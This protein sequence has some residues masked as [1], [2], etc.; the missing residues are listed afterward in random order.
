MRRISTGRPGVGSDV[1]LE[2]EEDRE[3]V[4]R[5]TAV[6]GFRVQPGALLLSFP[7]VRGND[8]DG[9]HL[10]PD[11]QLGPDVSGFDGYAGVIVR[12]EWW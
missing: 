6:D 11:G 9:V 7:Q 10:G 5:F 12:H 8:S 3:I 1:D 2:I 4:G